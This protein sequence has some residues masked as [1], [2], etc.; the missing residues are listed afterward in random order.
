MKR[1]I[2]AL[3]LIVVPAWPPA[4]DDYPARVVGIPDGDTLTALKADKTQVK[5]RLHA[6]DAPESSQDFGS[7]AKQAASEMAFGKEVTIRPVDTDRYGRTVAVVILPDGKSLNR[8]M[9]EQ[10]MA[11][12][13]R[14]YA[15]RDVILNRAEVSAKRAHVGLWSQPNPV[16]PWD[17]RKG[18]GLPVT[19]EVVGNRN[20][21]VYHTP[22]CASVGR[23]KDE[24]KLAFKSTGEAEG[25]GGGT[26]RR[27]IASSGL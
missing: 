25:R 17:W 7:R 24:N 1:F 26:G 10:G 19:A 16:A 15:P 5:I 14:E 13:Y 22:N 9:V 12:W 6:I 20:S 18:K 4:G 27:G 11:W 8:E 23:M 21:H 3:I 2:A